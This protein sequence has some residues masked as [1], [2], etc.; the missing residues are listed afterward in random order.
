MRRVQREGTASPVPRLRQGTPM[1]DA[2]AA[3]RDVPTISVVVPVYNEAEII[4]PNLTTLCDYLSR[5]EEM[6]RWEL[7]VVNDGS[8]DDTGPLAEAF[9]EG[10]DNVRLFHHR[11]N[12]RLGQALRY[13]FNN[14]EGDYVVTFDCDLSYALD[15][16]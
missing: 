11:T 1:E 8:T 4:T 14:C 10:R 7:I 3:P 12:F 5:L 6:Y 2:E 15:D 16:I 13:A 9:A